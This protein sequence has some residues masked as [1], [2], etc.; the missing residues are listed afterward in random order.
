MD[1]YIDTLLDFLSE[2]YFC[3]EPQTITLTENIFS[4]IKN[5]FFEDI[6]LQIELCE[7]N[8][9]NV[10][11]YMNVN[12][13]R[14]LE[15]NKIPYISGKLHIYCPKEKLESSIAAIF[16]H[17][18]THVYENYKR[19]KA[20]APSIYDIVTNTN[21]SN[22]TDR[23]VSTKYDRKMISHIVYYTTKFEVNA[24]AA[25]IY[26]T[27]KAHADE[28]IDAQDALDIIKYYSPIYQNFVTFG[29]YI[30]N[31]NIRYLDNQL[32]TK[33][34][35]DAWFS[36]MGEKKKCGCIVKKL[37]SLYSKNWRKLRKVIAKI[38]YDVYEKYGAAFT[39]DDDNLID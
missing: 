15:N 5:C 4:H 10:N 35:E 20:N 7:T 11:G 12:G 29:N 27:L 6:F 38:S 22:N 33:L 17:E 19:I 28:M 37:A 14:E 30:Q 2:F 24:Y 25:S 16:A 1:E 31:L 13:K 34:I 21:Y 39:V 26:G 23:Y 18:I 8:K 9:S 32:D 3:E 36:A